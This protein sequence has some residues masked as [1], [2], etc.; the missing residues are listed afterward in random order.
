[1]YPLLK[2]KLSSGTFVWYYLISWYAVQDGSNFFSL[3]M[4]SKSVAI[5]TKAIEQYLPV[6]RFIVLYEEVLTF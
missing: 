1:M 6:V 5:Q 4:K 3:W 2:M